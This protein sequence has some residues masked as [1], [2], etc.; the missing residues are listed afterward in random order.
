LP[1]SP[2][3][4]LRGHGGMIRRQARFLGKPVHAP[5]APNRRAILRKTTERDEISQ[6]NAWNDARSDT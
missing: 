4:P 2:E 1:A 5:A 6:A 3:I